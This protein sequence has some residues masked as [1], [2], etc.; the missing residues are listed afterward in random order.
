MCL[1]LNR[2]ALQMQ[3]DDSDSQSENNPVQRRLNK[4]QE[5]DYTSSSVLMVATKLAL[6]LVLGT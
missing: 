1:I 6:R 5:D 4:P 2:S 3:I